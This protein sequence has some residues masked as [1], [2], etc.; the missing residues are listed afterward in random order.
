MKISLVIPVY[1]EQEILAEVLEKYKADLR[2][3]CKETESSYEI[4]AVNDGCTDE[5]LDI[6]RKE[7]KLNRSL[8]IINLDTRY[9]KESAVTAGMEAAS[10]D[11]I[12]L[13]DVDL[14]NP[15]GVFERVM[16]EY[17]E[18]S[19]IVYAYREGI[20]FENTKRK[21]SDGIVRIATRFFGVEGKYTG[22]ANVMLYSRAAA[23]VLVSLPNK[24]KFLR[25]MDNWVG[26]EIKKISYATSYTRT[27]I[28]EKVRDAKKLDREQGHAKCPRSKAREH[29]PSKIYSICA[30]TLG[31]LLVAGYIALSQFVSVPWMWILVIFIAFAVLLFASFLFYARSVMIKRI[32]TVHTDEETLYI[33]ESVIN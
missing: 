12:I 2:H 21:V 15:V 13:A 10:G 18:G 8:R 31:L 16:V 33:I 4:I 14:L 28:R 7:G 22:K 26:F 19:N 6:L 32:G 30:L 1:N 23:D 24:N 17:F 29:T 27:E 11:V 20:G 25:T 3:I 9:G 5:S